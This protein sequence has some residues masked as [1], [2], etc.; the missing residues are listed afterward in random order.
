MFKSLAKLASLALLSQVPAHAEIQF[1]LGSGGLKAKNLAEDMHFSMGGRIQ[2]DYS[3]IQNELENFDKTQDENTIYIR[4]ARIFAAGEVK[5]WAFKAQFNISEDDGGTPEDLYIQYKGIENMKFT[6]GKQKEFIGLEEMESSK[7]ISMLERS[8][9]TEAFVIGRNY[10]VSA[11]YNLGQALV[12]IGL[13]EDD[14]ATNDELNMRNPAVTTRLVY[15]PKLQDQLQLH[16]GAAYS[17]RNEYNEDG[18]NL[19]L[20]GV[21]LGTSFYA[22]H[23]QAEYLKKTFTIKDDFLGFEK[24]L[25]RDGYYVQLGYVLTGEHRGYKPGAFKRIKPASS[26]CAYEVVLRYDSGD[27]HYNDFGLAKDIKG[28]SVTAG[29]NWYANNNVK[30][31]MNYG[32]AQSD[33]N[34]DKGQSFRLRAQLVW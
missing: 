29:L 20:Y 34:D 15:A 32:Q 14:Q 3:V 16:F 25:D 33:F 28:K 21:E 12:A 24:D 1:S 4:R 10:G 27:G 18:E 6:V 26:K 19:R 30:I 9:I 17:H 8:P 22:F 11:Q 5:D 23:A 7:D 2:L 31:G 13:F